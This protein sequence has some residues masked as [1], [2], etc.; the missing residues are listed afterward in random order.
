MLLGVLVTIGGDKALKAVAAA[1]KDSNAEV[2]RAGYRALGEWTSA[3]AGPE[4]LSLVKS[5]DPE[6]KIG[7]LRGYIRVARQFDIPRRP[8]DGHVPRDHDLGPAG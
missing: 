3:D 8:A 5:G 6:L 2:R 7:A 4:L 1:A